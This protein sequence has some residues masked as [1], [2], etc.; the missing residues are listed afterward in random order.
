[1]N[2]TYSVKPSEVTRSWHLIDATEDTLGRI[3]SQAAQLLLGKHKPSF[4][5]HIDTGD[6]VIVINS[7]N[8][9]VTGD[10]LKKKIYYRHSGYMG[11]LHERTLEEQLELDSN[12]VIEDAVY[13][14][15]PS[16]KL[17]NERMKRLKVFTDDNHN[18]EA[19][20]PQKVEA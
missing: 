11:G 8:L 18:H 17:R 20:K 13:G 19:Q 10:K 9:K 14:M 4:S 1:M 16:N 7:K 3:A 2:K 6:Y 15:L 12:K 5:K